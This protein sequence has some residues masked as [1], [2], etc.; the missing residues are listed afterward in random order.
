MAVKNTNIYTDL[1][2]LPIY[3]FYKCIDGRLEYLYEERKGSIND[4]ITSIWRRLYNDYCEITITKRQER[5][6]RLLSTVKWLEERLIYAPILI[7][8][9][10]KS[11]S[12]ERD[13]LII[14][15]NNWKLKINKNKNIDNELKRC[16]NILNNSRSKIK[17]KHEELKLIN[18]DSG[19]FNESLS[20][21]SQKTKL[22]KL[23]GLDVNTRTATV[24][25]WISY[26]KDVKDLKIN[27][28]GE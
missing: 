4:D 11:P 27:K 26:W 8:A 20:L 13:G 12:E 9:L 14:E 5:Y 19:E 1:D 6:Y 23:L 2:E 21:S 17:R 3:N 22:H 16:L 18:K 7:E 25:E 15:L 24:T 28:N 10:L